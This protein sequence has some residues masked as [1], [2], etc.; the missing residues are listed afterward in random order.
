MAHNLNDLIVLA[1]TIYGEARGENSLGKYAVA[2][3]I[4]NRWK[5]AK[6][7]KTIAGICLAKYQF[8]CW[9]ISDPNCK[10]LTEETFDPFD[11][12]FTSCLQEAT[13]VLRDGKHKDPTVGALHYHTKQIMPKWATGKEPCYAIGNH[14]FYNNID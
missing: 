13:F 14:L 6:G 4:Y 8:S 1:K 7:K 10:I 11:V 5:R 3:V 2:C 12:V 9:N